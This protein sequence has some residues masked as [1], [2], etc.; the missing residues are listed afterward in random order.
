MAALI[1]MLSIAVTVM[2]VR[3]EE[4]DLWRL[5]GAQY[6]AYCRQVPRWIPRLT[7]LRTEDNP[8]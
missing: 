1:A 3:K 4:P 2:V 8:E 6:E 5:F 7:P